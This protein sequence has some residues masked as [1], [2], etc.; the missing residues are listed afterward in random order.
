MDR[1]NQYIDRV[2][3]LPPAPTV[4]TELLRLF[5]DEQCDIDR[6]VELIS[7]DPSLTAE[8]LKRCNSAYLSG[9][10]PASDMFE[11][12][13]KLGFYEVYC[14]VVALVGA[15]TMSLAKTATGLDVS[16]LWRHSVV[17]A[18][19]AETLARVT[20]EAGA[21]AFTAGLLHDIG[22]LVLG[23][24]EGSA[25]SDLLSKAG[26]FGPDLANAEQE[27]LGVNHA[28]I[29]AC[30][31]SRWGL[32][33]NVVTAVRHHHDSSNVTESSARLAAIIQLANSLAHHL[34]DGETKDQDLLANSADAMAFLMV[35]NEIP[36]LSNQIQ[37]GLER[38]QGLLQ[39][40]T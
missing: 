20:N 21:V 22:K 9:A 35:T 15:R 14:V 29:G 2:S 12:V 36:L 37:T 28:S 6:V 25:Y 16:R 27:T 5:G 40:P 1:L 10:E 39:I 30:L 32:P 19:A 17:T 33:E 26:D 34:T 4:A 13:T 11:A 18:V 7:L 31:L 8:V 23:T 38:V 24:V 3:N